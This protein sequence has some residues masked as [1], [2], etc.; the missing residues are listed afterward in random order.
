MNEVS[1]ATAKLAGIRKALVS[2]VSEE[3]T[4]GRLRPSFD[5]STYE[6]YFV[7]A[8]NL[9]SSLKNYNPLLFADFQQ[10]QTRPNSEVGTPPRLHYSRSQLQQLIRD[11]DQI[12]ELRANSE[13]APLANREPKPNRVFITHG[14]SND[15]REVQSYIEKDILL[16]TLELAQEASQGMTIIEKLVSGSERC[17][18][19]VIVMTGDDIDSDGLA[20]ARENV[21]HEI[22]FFQAKYG[23][24]KVVLLHEDGVSIP[25]NLSGV[26]YIP[27]PKGAVSAGLHVLRRELQ[28]IYAS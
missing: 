11:V 10:I 2:A 14:R 15:W 21:M 23:R 19:A 27:F 8:S 12:F 6:H 25:T 13:L 9:L 1:V 5:A 24:S 22:G 4:A 17:D 7:Q 3:S 18:S 20:R 16:Q 28:A 26:V